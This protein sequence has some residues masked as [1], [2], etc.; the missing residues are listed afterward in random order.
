MILQGGA[1]G[2]HSFTAAMID[3]R[4]TVVDGA[5]LRIRLAPG[6]GGRIAARMK[7]YANQPTLRMPWDF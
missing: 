4:Q 7:R 6:A 2:E 1:Y 5:F 3:G